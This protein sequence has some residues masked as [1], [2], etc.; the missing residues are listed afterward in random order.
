MK[1][2]SKLI[3]KTKQNLST[4][5]MDGLFDFYIS[6]FVCQLKRLNFKFNPLASKITPTLQNFCVIFY[7]YKTKKCTLLMSLEG[8]SQF[9]KQKLTLKLLT[10]SQLR[11]VLFL[12]RWKVNL[13]D[14]LPSVI[15]CIKIWNLTYELKRKQL[16]LILI[17]TVIWMEIVSQ[18]LWSPLLS[19]LFYVFFGSF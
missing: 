15:R 13:S 17:G 8:H 9:P 5:K 6:S 12:Q 11:L 4:W 16:I 18:L 7:V 3:Y 14:L 1:I 2:G 10:K 19:L